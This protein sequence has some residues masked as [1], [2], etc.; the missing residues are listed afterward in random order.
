[1]K[2]EIRAAYGFNRSARDFAHLNI[3]EGRIFIDTPRTDREELRALA[4]FIRPGVTV[5]VLKM[6]DLGTGRK[7]QQVAKTLVAEGAVIEGPDDRPEPERVETRGRK[8]A[9]KLS[10]ERER[11][12]CEL[13]AD[14]LQ[15]KASILRR[16]S[17]EAGVPVDRDKMNYRTFRKHKIKPKRGTQ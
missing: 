16:I 3:T 13:W 8:S 7:A 2:I 11:Y 10:S 6:G 14:P 4:A 1:M 12:Y 9:V 15:D 17:E 5:V